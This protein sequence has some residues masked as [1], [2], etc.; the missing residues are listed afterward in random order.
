MTLLRQ[1]FFIPK[2]ENYVQQHQL[3][4]GAKIFLYTESNE[5][6]CI[7]ALYLSFPIN[8]E[9]YIQNKTGKIQIE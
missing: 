1:L 2:Y 4:T 3:Y 8:T 5:P 9:I 7:L 6:H